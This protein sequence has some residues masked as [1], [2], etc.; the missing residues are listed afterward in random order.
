MKTDSDL[1]RVTITSPAVS[2]YSTLVTLD[3]VRVKG[4]TRVALDITLNEPNRM[5]LD[6]IV[7]SVN[8]EA[9]VAVSEDER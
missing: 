6:L 2:G 8:A 1:H 5:S 7:D 4:V 3:G 9:M